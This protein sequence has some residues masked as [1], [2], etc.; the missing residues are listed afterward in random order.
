M[1]ENDPQQITPDDPAAHAD[2]AGTSDDNAAADQP[3]TA[4]SS[5]VQNLDE[6]EAALEAAVA[7]LPPSSLTSKVQAV[8]DAARVVVDQAHAAAADQPDTA[9]DP[10]AE[11][12]RPA[13][14]QGQIQDF[15]ATL[16]PMHRNLLAAGLSAF[17]DA[18]PQATGQAEDTTGGNTDPHVD[19]NGVHRL[20]DGTAVAL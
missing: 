1:T 6:A 18:S 3:D 13:T 15:L 10:D 4:P 20:S 14:E 7:D 16:D 2:P 17:D 11:P 5:P 12:A 8:V 19:E 9:D